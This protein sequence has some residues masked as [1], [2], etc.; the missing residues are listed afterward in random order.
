MLRTRWLSQGVCVVLLMSVVWIA[1]ALDPSAHAA[2][3]HTR[4]TQHPRNLILKMWYNRS[5]RPTDVYGRRTRCPVCC[6]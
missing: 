6:C 2:P 3:A 4:F 5:L 1:L